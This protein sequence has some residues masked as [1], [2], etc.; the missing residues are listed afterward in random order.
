MKFKNSP[1]IISFIILLACQPEI[2]D[3]D[4]NII[5][6]DSGNSSSSLNIDTFTEIPQDIAGCSCYYSND[7]TEFVQSKYIYVSDFNEL[8]YVKI[9]GKLL[10]FKQTKLNRKND[11]TLEIT[12][13]HNN[14]EMFITVK[15][16]SGEGE[17]E[18]ERSREAGTL[19]IKDD[20]GNSVSKSF[21]GMCGC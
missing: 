1:F 13:R 15:N 21:Y 5:H 11:G 19:T 9:N 10:Q 4:K 14:Y 6:S 3:G 17:Q 7:S 2:H 8:S 18:E 12:A 16:I 20:K